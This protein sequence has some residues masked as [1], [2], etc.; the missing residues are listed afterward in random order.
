MNRRTLTAGLASGFVAAL[1]GCVSRLSTADRTSKTEHRTFQVQSGTRLAVENE[2]GS[3]DVRRHDGGDV[4]VTMKIHA[5]KGGSL[6]AV[7]LSDAKTADE[8]RL[9]VHA[10]A[11]DV[12]VALTVRYPNSVPVGELRSTNGRIDA[13]V[14][15]AGDSADVRTENGS[16]DVKLLEIARDTDVRTENGSID[17]ALASDLDATVSATTKNGSLN[18]SGLDFSSEELSM[19]GFTG[20]LGDGSDDLSFETENGSISLSTTS[21]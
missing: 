17:A 7:S 13:T 3:I 1:T 11:D 4:D 21:E 10:D 19:T 8:L 5:R 9:R 20:V 2:N 18:A 15:T 12:S 6:D 16:I 14:V